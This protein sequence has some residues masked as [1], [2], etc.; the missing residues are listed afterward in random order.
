VTAILLAAII[1]GFAA[2]YLYDS[3]APLLTRWAAGTATGL[4]TLSLTG[5]LA[6]SILGVGWP[7]VLVAASLTFSPAATFVVKA[8]REQL[9]ADFSRGIAT[10]RARVRRPG[11]VACAVVGTSALAVLW[12]IMDRAM[13][14]RP[15]GIW[16]GVLHNFGDLPF[17]L[18]V[19]SRFAANNNL[20]PEHPSFAGV[21]FTY[22]F[23]TDFLSALFVTAG[24]DLRTAIVLPAILGAGALVLLLH[25]WTLDLTNDALAAA[26]A[27]ILMLVG[28][29]LG[30]WVFLQEAWQAPGNVGPLLTRLPHD[31]TIRESGLRFGNVI[32]TLLITQRGINLALP[33]AVV[34]FRQWWL[35]AH[36]AAG[37]PNESVRR[38]LA[39]GVV[40]GLLPLIHGHTYM[41]VVGMAGCLA[42]LLRMWSAWIAFVVVAAGLGL[43]Q[44]LWLAKGSAVDSASFVG[45]QFG[46]DRGETGAVVFWLM[47]T[48]ALIPIIVWALLARGESS[49]VPARLRRFYLP[50]LLCFVVPNVVRLAPWIWDNIKVLVYWFLASIPLVSLVL[51]RWYRSGNW[52][53]GLAI[54]LFIS[55]TAAGTLDLWRLLS[56]AAELRVLSQP[57]IDFAR[58]I[59]STT[60]TNATVL[61][62]P[63][64]NHSVA[65]SGRRSLMGFPG[66]VWSQGVDPGAREREIKVIYEGGQDATN[67]LA[68]YRV[69]YV[70]IGPEERRF[71]KVDDMFFTRYPVVAILGAYRLHRVPPTE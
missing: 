12:S 66:H 24:A 16:T 42:L 19:V 41:V 21:P 22:P 35:A 58:L 62:A 26:V 47:N 43:P 18:A 9:R 60:E 63:I 40:A 48:G 7:A 44:L 70:V 51:A 4:A 49:G 50:F 2:T 8:H 1:G 38:M 56:R 23:L 25:R 11:A 6:A 15:N 3:R 57:A 53:R 34:V 17:H 46:W 65:L 64:H 31:Y 36:D 28:G 52:R 14:V 37:R 39:A 32:T 33:L 27:P 20:P 61:H 69:D 54:A 29:G 55:L 59:A 10:I 67:L 30:W 13:I 68:R 5:F 71:S 45:W